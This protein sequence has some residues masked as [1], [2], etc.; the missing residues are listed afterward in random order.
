MSAPL[1]PPPAAD[2]ARR[3]LLLWATALAILIAVG[4]LWALTPLRSVIEPRELTA[5]VGQL[6]GSG[7]APLVVVAVFVAGGLLVLPVTPMVVATVATFGPVAGFFY[8]LTGTIVSGALSFAIGRRLGRRHVEALTGTRL[9]RL[10]RRFASHG[11]LAIALLRMVPVA[12]F[13]VVSL[14]A[15][16]SHISC[17]QFL[18]GTLLGIAPGMIG[19][20]AVMDRVAAAVSDPAPWRLLTAA[21]VALAVIAGMLALRY[22]ARRRVR[23]KGRRSRATPL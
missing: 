20:I 18:A 14:A 13:T 11:L 22:W 15:G 12:H 16:T 2:V 7:W 1:D 10:S 21:A 3:R 8:A 23:L 19:I 9:H 5:A 4:A 17:R 6:G